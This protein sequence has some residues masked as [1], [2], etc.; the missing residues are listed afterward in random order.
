MTPQQFISKWRRNRGQESAGAQEWFIDLCRMV[1]HPTPAEMD[2]SQQWYTFERSVREATGRLGRA[3]VYKQGY[4]AWEFKGL[5]RDLDAAYRQLL[6]YREALNNPPLLVVSDFQTIRVHTNFTNKVPIVHS[7]QLDD[8]HEPESLEILHGVFHNPDALE[9]AITPN[10]VT[11]A[12]ANIFAA[13]AGSMRQR[14]IDSLEVARF[15]NRLVFCFFAQDVGLL[16]DRVVTR[17]CENY[18]SNPSEFDLGVR[19]LFHRMNEGGRF[20]VSPIRHFNGDLF[21]KPDTILMEPHE[22]E[23]LTEATERNWAHIEPSILGTL[24][25]RVVDPDKEMLIGAEYTTEADILTVVDPV[26]MYPLRAE[27]NQVE[28]DIGV[29][30]MPGGRR[31]DD[32]I[33]GFLQ[34]FQA[35]LSSVRVLDPACGSGNFLYVALRQMH[36]LEKKVLM[37]AADLEL[38]GFLPEVS[39]AQFY[40]IELNEY[41]SDLARTAIWIGHLQWLIENGHQYNREPVLGSLNTIERRDA[42]IDLTDPERPAEP[43]WPAADYIVGNPPFLGHVPFRERLGDQYA[44]AIYALYGDRIPNSSDLCCYW[45]EKARAMIEAGDTQRAGLLATQAIRFQSNRPVLERVKETG[46]IFHVVSDREWKPNDPPDN[47]DGDNGDNGHTGSNSNGGHANGNGNGNGGHA[48][49]NGANGN[50]ENGWRPPASV[51]IAIVC[52]DDGSERARVLDGEP[53]NNINPDLTGGA[54]LTRAKTL[55]EN[56]GASFMGATKIGPFE[57]ENELAQEMLRHP[58][59]HG[60]PNNEV[61]KRWMI[62]RDINQVSRDMWII[63]FGVDMSED[64]AALYEAPFEYVRANVKPGRDSHRDARARANWWLHGRPRP[65]M[66]QALEG[67]SRYIGTSMVSRHRIFAWIDGDV[68]PDATMIV[69]ARDD[70]YF[71]GILQ[72]RIHLAWAAGAGTQLEDRPRYTPTTCFEM[73]P[74]PEPTDAQRETIATAAYELNQLRE[75]WLNPTDLF[76]NPA[77]DADRLRRRTLTNLY[78]EYPTWLSNAHARLDAAVA[79]AYGWPPDLADGE[80]L[81]R[82]LDLNLERAAAG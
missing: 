30:L 25:E 11:E 65:G 22:L 16:P 53:V 77:L 40:G 39:P 13:I 27:W 78:N 4:F 20:G 19:E 49:G 76:G 5:H 7:I 1:E 63:D 3:D 14:G 37:R 67:L 24:F 56:A 73:F 28:A 41:A 32:K 57:I 33:R 42:I 69:F 23:R 17:L 50:G 21:K 46:D 47:E 15:L 2:R 64:D 52:F 10:E 44:D 34:D 62:G 35:R 31:D 43:E 70:D 54:D 74:F 59:P 58:N 72:S 6:R 75:N 29:M 79:A 80:V 48:N 82:L 38:R 18:Q 12:T 55:A 45:F 71:F 68:L 26:V 51:H 81:E 61:V 9:P 8:L 36:D 66:R 60:R